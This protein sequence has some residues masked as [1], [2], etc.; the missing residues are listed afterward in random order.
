MVSPRSQ[1]PIDF[2]ETSSS[3]ASSSWLSRRRSRAFRMSLPVTITPEC[4]D[5]NGH[6]RTHLTR[7]TVFPVHPALRLIV[8]AQLVFVQHRER[9]SLTVLT[10]RTL[11]DTM[12][13]MQGRHVNGRDLRDIREQQKM[14]RPKLAELS[15]VS[16]SWIKYIEI[17]SRQP[18]GK[19]V[20]A[21]AKALKVDIA[22]F[23]TDLDAQQ[24]RAA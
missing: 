1:R 13:T 24:R 23:T 20:F 7:V 16:V 21:L 3:P 2:E 9:V 8:P 17:N 4:R 22:A 6:W 19:T 10:V 11:R 5:T 14:L 12:R 18:S 15:G